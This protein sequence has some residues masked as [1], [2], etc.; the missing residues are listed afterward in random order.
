MR[1]VIIACAFLAGLFALA[2]TASAQ[3]GKEAY[4]AQ[5]RADP[6][7]PPKCNYK[8]LAECQAAM[9]PDSGNC[10]ENP[11]KGKM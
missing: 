2:G 10:I 9:K 8:T 4:C 11:N 5:V 3:S 1:H 7:S 6:G